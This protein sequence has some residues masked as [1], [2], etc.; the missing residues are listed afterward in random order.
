MTQPNEVFSELKRIRFGSKFRKKGIT[1]L[2]MWKSSEDTSETAQDHDQRAEFWRLRCSELEAG[3][4]STV[5]DLVTKAEERQKKRVKGL[6][7]PSFEELPSLFEIETKLRSLK[8]GKAAGND[9]IRSELCQAAA[10]PLAKHVHALASKFVVS[11]CEPIQYKGGSLVLAYKNAGPKDL[12]ASYRSLLLSSHLGKTTRGWL[13]T[14]FLPIYEA[15]SAPTHFAAKKGG[16]VAHAATLLKAVVSG[17]HRRG[18]SVTA[19]FVDIASAFYR[20]VREL[21]VDLTSSDEEIISVLERFGLNEQHFALLRKQL[22]QPC[23]LQQSGCSQRQQAAIDAVLSDTWYTVPN[24]DLITATKAGSRPGDTFADLIFSFVYSHMLLN[25]RQAL[26]AEGYRVLDNLEFD[27]SFR[28]TTPKEVHSEQAPD[29]LDLTW[30]DDLVIVQHAEDSQTLMSRTTLTAGLLHDLCTQ[31]GLQINYKKGKTECLA[32]F[33]GKGSRAMKMKYFAQPSPHISAP[34]TTTQDLQIRL[35]HQYKH[36]GSQIHVSLKQLPEV[37]ARVG[38][39]LQIYNKY[40]RAVFQNAQIR[41]QIR[42]RLVQTMVLSVLT[43]NQGN[44]K[45]LKQ[46]EFRCYANAVWRIYRGV[47]RATVSHEVLQCWTNERVAST[48]KLPGPQTLLHASRLRY[49]G[50]L[51]RSAPLVVWWFLHYEGEW[52][53]AIDASFQWLNHHT[54]GLQAAKQAEQRAQNWHEII[55]NREQ[56]KRYIRIATEHDVATAKDAEFV[57]RWHFD[58]ALEA[59]ETG[60]QIEV[61]SV[62]KKGLEFDRTPTPMHQHGCVACRVTFATKTAWSTHAFKRHGRIA[63]ERRAICDS[64]CRCCRKQY[65]TTTRLL[66]HFR[67]SPQCA[68]AMI[69]ESGVVQPV[70]PGI[71]NVQVDQ[72]SDLP[73]PVHQVQG[74]AVQKAAVQNLRHDFDPGLLQCLKQALKETASSANESEGLSLCM[75]WIRSSFEDFQT[76]K[77]T[78]S[79]LQQELLSEN[80]A[81]SDLE[82]VDFGKAVI[83]QVDECTQFHLLFTEQLPDATPQELRSATYHGIE[84]MADAEFIWSTAW[85]IP[86]SR[87]RHLLIL[88]VFSGHRRE[89]DLSSLIEGFQSPDSVIVTIVAVDIIFDPVRCDVSKPEIRARWITLGRQGAIL[90]MLCGPPCETYSSARALGGLAGVSEGDGGPRQ[91]RTGTKPFGVEAMTVDERQHVHL[92]NVLLC[93]AYD[94]SLILLQWALSFF[95][96]EHPAIPQGKDEQ[97]LPSSW[98]LGACR[99]LQRHPEVQLHHIAQGKFGALSPKPTT[100]MVKSLITLRHHLACKGTLDMPPPLTMGRQ[101]DGSFATAELKAYPPRMCQAIA[102]AVNDFVRRFTSQET[103]SQ[104]CTIDDPGVQEWAEAILA[105]SNFSACRSCRQCC[106]IREHAWRQRPK[107]PFK[108]RRKKYNRNT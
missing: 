37:K 38:Q 88:H 7:P 69:E 16:N 91:L 2:P 50:A 62:L 14:K 65:S 56:W 61:G 19:L 54:S 87:T 18:R 12:L 35:T 36:L 98:K 3:H 39:A 101:R 31:R 15:N 97:D 6:P 48:L 90:G 100:L 80:L 29:L 26:A 60:L 94:M 4:L 76:V 10:V 64:I 74:D 58:F 13:R 40:R 21:V 104:N 83:E 93:F 5:E 30:A 59:V 66:R 75:D 73:L 46:D 108:Q 96:V 84:Q 77:D 71:G 41:L 49:L 68:T 99:M 45:L 55:P 53:K 25:L 103:T 24:S 89:M 85:R 42:V 28:S 9:L 1:P 86:R 72:D 63:P 57:S 44:W 105:N 51:W 11:M 95:L 20:V 92:S 67:Y 81:V 102:A 22:E 52:Y 107:G 27:P 33:C 43:Y 17:A 47:L 8:K 78:I 70:K 79:H 106:I 82:W 23:I 32:V 34:S